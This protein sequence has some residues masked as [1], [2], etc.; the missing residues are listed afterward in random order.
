MS[1][2]NIA[3]IVSQSVMV[4]A[5]WTVSF[6]ASAQQQGEGV[7][8]LFAAVKTNML[9][10][11]ALVPN[12][13]A[14]F[15]V[16]RN[17]TV[18]ADWMYAW[19]SKKNRSRYWRIYGGDINCRYWF[20]SAAKDKPLT[21]HHA[22]VYAGLFTFDFE[23]GGTA[24]MGG[25]PGHS[26]WKRPMVNVGVEYGYSLPVARHLNIDF[27]VGVGYIGG[28]VEKFRPAEGTY[29]WESTSRRTWIGPSKAEVSLVW[30]LGKGNVNAGK[31]GRR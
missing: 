8:P 3:C 30:L 11:A 24:Y 2:K 16:G 17:I 19:W 1:V 4:A 25:S 29:V 5:L 26:L 23:W 20:G 22:G 7:K 21:G 15:Y 13:G 18:G 31:G 9:Y 27:T 14:E 12:I 10:D 6:A 28:T